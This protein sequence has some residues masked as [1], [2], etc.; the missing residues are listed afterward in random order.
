[1]KDLGFANAAIALAAGMFA[2]VLAARMAIPSIVLLL[3]AGTLLG[4]DVLGWLD[5]GAFGAGR[6]DL[7]T[8]AVIVILF[9]GGLAL[10]I[11]RLRAQQK[12]LL[13]LL[14]LGAAL[15]MLV[16]TLAAYAILDMPG[17]VAILYGSLMIVTGPTVVKPLLSRIK[18]ARRVRELLVSEGVL[19]DPIGAIVALV[20]AE[21]V[22][23][24]HDLVVSGGLVVFRL[25]LG[26]AVGFAAG[27]ILA[28]IMKRRWIP[29]DLVNPSVLGIAVVVAALASR[30][31]AEAGLMAAVAQ[32]ITMANRSVPDVGRLREFK[33]TLT[34][35]LLSF[36]FVVL[37]ADLSL[38]EVTALGWDG[39]L[40]VALVAW[41]ARPLGVFLST[42]GSDLSWKERAFVA[43][44][45][46]R[47]IVAAA[48]AG[49][50]HNLLDEAEIPGG[51][52]LEALVFVTV[53]A[54]VTLQG[55]TARPL[56]NLLKIDFPSLQ[57]TLVIG[58]SR[59]SRLVARTLVDLGRNV[60]LVDRNPSLCR[61]AQSEGLVAITGDAF[62]LDDLERAGGRYADTVLAITTN[63]S[64][65]ELAAKRVHENLLVERV[66]AIHENSEDDDSQLF[67]GNFPGVDEANRLVRLGRLETVEHEVEAAEWKGRK[68]SELPYAEG[69]FAIALRRGDSVLVA[70][71]G[72]VLAVGDRLSCA[73]PSGAT[74]NLHTDL[75]SGS[76]PSEAS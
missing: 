57:G 15:S 33:E 51:A 61:A 60:V 3:V 39:L 42:I 53:A 47:G 4:P 68:L 23:G 21:W 34:L 75:L 52:S 48:V 62:S 10:D 73:R 76:S 37:A 74:S 6:A 55:L 8:L 71:A 2:Q 26:G 70:T 63:A 14:T 31:S 17:S 45:C 56:A 29:E 1:M 20:A 32:G 24:Q 22:I 58:A 7:V 69:E 72:E 66:L 54:T 5:P 30:I 40:V 25:A 67:P 13:L 50:F 44:I 35:I 12:S 65:N 49:F 64:L 36:L 28:E 59:F 11:N 41:V 16:G 9:E 38:S 18:L 46:P 43:W 27:W 19:I